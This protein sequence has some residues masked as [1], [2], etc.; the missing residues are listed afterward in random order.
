MLIGAGGRA[1][2][3][4]LYYLASALPYDLDV[5]K[6]KLAMRVAG[7]HRLD[8]IVL[9]HWLKL[10]SSIQMDAEQIRSQCLELA[11][12]LPDT[13]ADVV[14]SA[15]TDGLDHKILRRLADALTARAER[16]RKILAT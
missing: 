5:K 11:E 14:K 1:R 9:R 2:L 16:C 13:V 6:L 7:K 8:E 12:R 4:P 3:A 10:A 15:R